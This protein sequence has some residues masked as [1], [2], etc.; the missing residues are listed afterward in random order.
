MPSSHHTYVDCGVR[1]NSIC[2]GA[3]DTPLLGDFKQQMFEQTIDWAIDQMCGVL[4][5]RDVANVMGSGPTQARRST[6]TT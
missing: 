6:A 3:I 1:T 2:P 4:S 5:S